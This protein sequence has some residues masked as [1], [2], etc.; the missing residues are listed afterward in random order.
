MGAF[1]LESPLEDLR[2]HLQM[3]LLLVLA[4]GRHSTGHTNTAVDEIDLASTGHIRGG[5]EAAKTRPVAMSRL[6]YAVT[7]PCIRLSRSSLCLCVDMVVCFIVIMCVPGAGG[8]CVP[9]A[10]V[11][12]VYSRRRRGGGAIG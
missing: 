2:V 3:A 7:V 10:S 8:A 6:R 1:P 4:Q 11:L 12:G 5:Q 9:T